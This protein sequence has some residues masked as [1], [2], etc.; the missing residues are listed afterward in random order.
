[1]QGLGAGRSAATTRALEANGRHRSPTIVVSD[2][3]NVTSLMGHSFR[4]GVTAKQTLERLVIMGEANSGVI[5]GVG[6]LNEIKAAKPTGGN[7]SPA[8][9][10]GL[11]A[12]ARAKENGILPHLPFWHRIADFPFVQHGEDWDGPKAVFAGLL[13]GRPH[14]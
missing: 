7:S 9:A 3:C 2:L 10:T 12:G 11:R 13:I 5:V 4:H 8:R 6:R 1:M 14:S